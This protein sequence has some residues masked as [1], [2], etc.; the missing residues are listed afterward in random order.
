MKNDLPVKN[1]I[2]IPGHEI[3]VTTSRSSGAGGQHVNKADTRVTL[4][5]N[6]KN[7]MALDDAQ[8]ERVMQNLKSRLTSEGDFIIHNSETRSQL[9]NKEKAFAILAKDISKALH[10]PKKRM[11]TRVPKKAKESRLRKKAQRS[12][13][14]KQRSKKYDND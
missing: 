14:K 11:K 2:V 1:G 7:T 8:K 12:E 13:I 4:R 3:E 5:W 6:V 10:V 9:Q